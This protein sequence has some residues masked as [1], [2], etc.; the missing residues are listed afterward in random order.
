MQKDM[1]FMNKSFSKIS[2]LQG[3]Q[4]DLFKAKREFSFKDNA[5][6]YTCFGKYIA[7]TAPSELLSPTP[8]MLAIIGEDL[9]TNYIAFMTEENSRKEFLDWVNQLSFGNSIV[10]KGVI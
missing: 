5:K 2:C 7:V 9:R 10:F 8:C 1:S 3:H 6:E 4:Y